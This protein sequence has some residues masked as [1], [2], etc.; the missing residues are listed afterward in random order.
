MQPTIEHV[1][2]D[3]VMRVI[4]YSHDNRFA[5]TAREQFLVIGERM[6]NG[7]LLRESLCS[8]WKQVTDSHD[9]RLFA[10]R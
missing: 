5:Q 1:H 7:I 2:G 10:G 4:G 6:G 9:I 3:G 8:L